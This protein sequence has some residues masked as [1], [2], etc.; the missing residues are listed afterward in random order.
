MKFNE[1]C[2]L[3]LEGT[4]D[5]TTKYS[6][7]KIGNESPTFSIADILRDPNDPSKGSRI[8]LFDNDAESKGQQV[9]SEQHIR[10]QLRL[11][12]W[13]A[14]NIIKKFRNRDTAFSIGDMNQVIKDLLERYETRI[15][16]K[17]RLDN[18]NIGR[19]VR[20][21]GNMLLPPTGMNPEGKSVLVVPGMDP[22]ITAED[23][24]QI[25]VPKY[26]KRSGEVVKG[27]P[28]SS[29]EVVKTFNGLI[30]H[31]DEMLD[32][33]LIQTI[34]DIVSGGDVEKTDSDSEASGYID[35]D[36]RRD[37]TV[38]SI[39]KDERILNIYSPEAV[40]DV[41]KGMIKSGTL[42]QNEDGTL[43]M[44]KESAE[45]NP[46]VQKL[47][48]MRLGRGED[49]EEGEE[50]VPEPTD[51][52]STDV[53]PIQPKESDIDD[54]ENIETKIPEH[55]PSWWKSRKEKGSEESEEGEPKPEEEEETDE[56]EE[57]EKRVLKRYGMQ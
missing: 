40:K 31:L 46:D 47:L 32:P 14:K 52:I 9:S 18:T 8:Y 7:L 39:L 42:V 44:A 43:S 26:R 23:Q 15:L 19:A 29:R 11:V 24:N 36:E 41:L 10:R 2:S 4:V 34:R 57:T 21:I 55:K 20:V 6:R 50:P 25:V 12:N 33:D 28:I 54:E 22:N 51:D 5:K 13:I 37:V 35:T 30:D 53:E 45:D 48:K 49:K 1:L 17:T 56:D 38:R 16:G 3:V 27:A